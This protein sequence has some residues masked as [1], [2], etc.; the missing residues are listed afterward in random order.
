MSVFEKLKKIYCI[1]NTFRYRIVTIF[2]RI[3]LVKS[4]Y[5]KTPKRIVEKVSQGEK[6]RVLFLI[7]EP[8]KWKAQTLLDALISH[9]NYDPFLVFT[10]ADIDFDLSPEKKKGKLV[11]CERYFKSL[12]IPKFFGYEY[13]RDRYIS[14][15]EFQPDVVIYQQPWKLAQ[16]HQPCYVAQYA[17]TFYIPYYVANYGVVSTD[18]GLVFH[19]MLFGYFVLSQ[20]WSV[21]YRN[22]VGR[23]LSACRFIPV[24][25]PSLDNLRYANP[26]APGGYVIYAP[27]WSFHHPKNLNWEN[28][29][30]FLWT[31][32]AMLEYAQAH[33]EI[34]WVFKPHP[35]LKYTLVRC[36]V[37]TEAEADAYWEAWESL[38]EV[39]YD[40]NY[41]SYF[42]NSS[43]LITD[44]GSFLTEY[45]CTGLPIIHLISHDNPP[46]VLSVLKKL[47]DTYYQVRTLEE[48]NSVCNDVIINGRDVKRDERVRMLRECGLL[49]RESSAQRI[50]SYWAELFHFSQNQKL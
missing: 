4:R 24:G 6:I 19:R 33:P 8:A 44:C 32:K 41:L 29:S 46:E 48:L 5:K 9:P 47:Y 16:I 18:C 30:T 35:T 43:V 34:K 26:P 22:Y 37:M 27:H 13:K 14:L 15:K 50:L 12:D 23:Q 39:S 3:Q 45:A 42:N 7:N 38:G 1:C 31:G 20:D 17:L 21:I 11:F 49:E 36:N 2:I 40:S 10:V 25:H 28:Y